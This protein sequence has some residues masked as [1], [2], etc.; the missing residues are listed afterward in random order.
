MLPEIFGIPLYLPILAVALV[1]LLDL[2]FWLIRREGF[3][4]REVAAYIALLGLFGFAG[5]K[6]ASL[7]FQGDIQRIGTEFTAGLRYPGAMLGVLGSGYLLRR[8]LPPGLSFARFAD[9]WAPA[10]ALGCAVGRLGCLAT[11]CCYG[12]VSHL[13]WSLRYPR[14]SAPWW[15]HYHGGL[16]DYSAHASAPVHPFPVYLF[17]MELGLVAF[18]LWLQKR[19]AYDGQVVLVFLAT[20]GALKFGIEFVR[21]PYHWMHQTVLPIALIAAVVL[22]VRWWTRHPMPSRATA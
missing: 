5:A 20:H 18:T 4:R 7:A 16:I 8:M 17:A 10:F 14:G 13:L 19:R 12:R 22:A 11:G 6:L 2:L 9:L 1:A 3:A 21:S 15:E